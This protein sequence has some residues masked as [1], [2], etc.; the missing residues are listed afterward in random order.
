MNQKS[1]WIQVFELFAKKPSGSR[2]KINKE[3]TI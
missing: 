1:L 3:S 2:E